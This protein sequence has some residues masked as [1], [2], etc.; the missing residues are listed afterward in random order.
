MINREHVL[1]IARLARLKLSEEEIGNFTNQLGSI[2]EYVEQLNSA[3]IAGVEPTCFVAP[4]HDPLRDDKEIPSL[5]R[6]EVLKNAPNV[7]KGHFAVPKV[8]GG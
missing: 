8:I 7:K 2:L 1:H 6:E 5:D 4:S 3:D